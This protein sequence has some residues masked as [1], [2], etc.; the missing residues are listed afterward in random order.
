MVQIESPD[1]VLSVET[2]SERLRPLGRLYEFLNFHTPKLGPEMNE[3]FIFFQTSLR[4]MNEESLYGREL[5]VSFQMQPS[6]PP[7]IW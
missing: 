6:D 7:K 5:S 3:L 4:A 2:A 1:Q